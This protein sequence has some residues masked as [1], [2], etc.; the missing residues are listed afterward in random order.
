MTKQ[1]LFNQVKVRRFPEKNYHAIWYNLK[2]IRI[3]Q[4]KTDELEPE[5][6]EFFDIGINTKCNAE[7]PFCYVNA[8]SEGE[9]YEGICDIWKK[10]MDQ[11][12]EDRVGF[13]DKIIST[14]RPFQIALGQN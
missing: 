1:E 14:R 8:T 13:T 10:W 7:C 4:G 3:G 2:T 5:Y 12:P 11:F 6:S 9:N